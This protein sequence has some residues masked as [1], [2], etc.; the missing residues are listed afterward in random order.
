MFLV[1]YSDPRKPT[2][3]LLHGPC[4]TPCMLPQSSAVQQRM[5]ALLPLPTRSG[6]PPLNSPPCSP[7]VDEQK[8]V[9]KHESGLFLLR[10][11]IGRMMPV[12]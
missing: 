8:V 11:F 5:Q 9:R 10:S 4:H 7:L 12:V 6:I 3:D 2:D 1:G